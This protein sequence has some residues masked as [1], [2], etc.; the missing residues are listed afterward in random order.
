[1]SLFRADFHFKVKPTV[2]VTR[3][4]LHAN[5]QARKYGEN[6]KELIEVLQL[7]AISYRQHSKQDIEFP[8]E[9]PVSISF[10]VSYSDKIRRDIDNIVKA[11]LDALVGAGVLADDNCLIVRELRRCVVRP[12]EKEDKLVIDIKPYS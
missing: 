9:N 8:I 6:K 4:S 7:A 1:M 10:A 12:G 5:P 2:R 3:G 11:L